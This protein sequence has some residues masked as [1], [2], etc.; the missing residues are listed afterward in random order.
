MEQAVRHLHVIAT[1]RSEHVV[2]LAEEADLA[3]LVHLLGGHS[4]V[5]LVGYTAQ[6]LD[7]AVDA[8]V[9]ELLNPDA[10]GDS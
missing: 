6:P 2:E 7:K 3:D 1:W 9:D 10:P 8:A 5:K 4:N